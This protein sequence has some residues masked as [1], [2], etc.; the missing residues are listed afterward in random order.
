MD[1]MKMTKA[2]L[3]E[4]CT[5]FENM[6]NNSVET[7]REEKRQLQKLCDL[8]E[9]Q[10]QTYHRLWLNDHQLTNSYKV[11]GN[12][13]YTLNAYLE[14]E[15]SILLKIKD[16]LRKRVPYP[17]DICPLCGSVDEVEDRN[18]GLFVLCSECSQSST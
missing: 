14:N 11:M 10:S 12:S 7:F 15:R 4:R 6:Y 9:K 8:A 1:L 2:Q 16:S 3:I 13:L 17:T 18:S 5:T